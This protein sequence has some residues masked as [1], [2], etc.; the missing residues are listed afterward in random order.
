MTGKVSY[1]KFFR[2][3][4][5]FKSAPEDVRFYFILLDFILFYFILFSAREYK[6]FPVCDLFVIQRDGFQITR[7]FHITADETMTSIF[8]KRL[9]FKTN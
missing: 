4:L 1:L 9:Q 3:V 8:G 6:I 7:I 5:L 2:I